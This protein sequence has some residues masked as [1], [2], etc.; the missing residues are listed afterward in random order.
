[1]LPS[2][3][4]HSWG[5]C[6]CFSA[7]CWGVMTPV[8]RGA[9]GP[10]G[11]AHRYCCRVSH[12]PALVSRSL[13]AST[14]TMLMKRMKLSCGTEGGLCLEVHR[15]RL[16]GEGPGARGPAQASPHRLGDT[17]LW[18]SNSGVQGSPCSPR[19]GLVAGTCGAAPRALQPP[20]LTTMEA[21][22]GTWMIHFLFPELKS[23]HLVEAEASA[24]TPVLPPRA[25][26][27]S[28]PRA[29]LLC[30]Q[31]AG[32]KDGGVG[33]GQAQGPPKTLLLKQPPVT[34]RGHLAEGGTENRSWVHSGPGST[35]PLPMLHGR[36]GCQAYF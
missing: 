28:G 25:C 2:T 21:R 13:V 7:R 4:A 8:S 17:G 1:M 27:Q 33:C 11:A 23:Q 36:R 22:M 32:M 26:P 18:R 29:G 10:V 35:K 12:R 14:R 5:L 34:L 15:S 9:S 6:L 3:Q 19:Q 30:Q 16:G 31:L 20:L 24:P